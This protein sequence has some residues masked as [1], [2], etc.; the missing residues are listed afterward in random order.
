[1]SKK[2]RWSLDVGV[3]GGPAIAASNTIEVDACDDV[4]VPAVENGKTVKAQV[5]PGD[6]GRVKFIVVHTESYENPPTVK[7][8]DSPMEAIEL[9]APL[10]LI[11][12]EAV[13]LLGASPQ[14][15]DITNTTSREESD[16]INVRVIVGRDVTPLPS[17]DPNPSEEEGAAPEEEGAAP[18][19]EGAAPEEEGA[20]PEMKSKG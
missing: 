15:L 10:V 3:V 17:P 8:T 20:A 13:G 18:E 6:L 7:V 2:I 9:T 5:Q 1:M 16:P 19:E 4:D 12:E 14:S 11:G